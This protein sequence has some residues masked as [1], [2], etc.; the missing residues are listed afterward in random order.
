MEDY[1]S[2]EDTDFVTFKFIYAFVDNIVLV[3]EVNTNIIEILN[4]VLIRLLAMGLGSN[5]IF[6]TWM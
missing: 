3:R 5:Q 4:Q 6:W 2:N 1:K